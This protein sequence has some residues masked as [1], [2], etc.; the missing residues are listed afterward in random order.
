VTTPTPQRPTDT[1]DSRIADSLQLEAD[2]RAIVERQRVD[3]AVRKLQSLLA[4]P[5][6]G[7]T[8]NPQPADWYERVFDQMACA[9]PETCTCTPKESS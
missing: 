6:F 7:H 4:T 9:H 2:V 8:P 5:P 3:R 1:L